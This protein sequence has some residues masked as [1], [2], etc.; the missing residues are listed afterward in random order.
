MKRLAG[1]LLAIAV[2]TVGAVAL[3]STIVAW[4]PRHEVV[5]SVPTGTVTVQRDGK[6]APARAGQTLDDDD[7]VA[8]GPDGRAEI[9]SGESSIATLAAGTTVQVNDTKDG[10]S[11]E[12]EGGAVEVTVR[13]GGGVLKVGNGGRELQATDADFEVAI[14]P[15]DLFVAEVARGE[16]KAT[17]VDGMTSIEAGQRASIPST[18]PPVLQPISDELLLS[19]AWPEPKT[20]APNLVVRGTTAPGSRVRIEGGKSA[21]DAVADARGEFSVDIPLIDGKNALSV[22]ARDPFGKVAPVDRFV[23]ERDTRGP[24]IRGETSYS[25]KPP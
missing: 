4:S 12:L 25:G 9:R 17:G 1:L 5:I 3:M 21:V 13:P 23:V 14:G 15:D 18:G 24:S 2:L 8:T 7:I 6:S 20:R 16:V 10:L 11:L 19:M 22:T